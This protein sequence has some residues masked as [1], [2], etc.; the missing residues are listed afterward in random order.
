MQ[1]SSNF[2]I[3]G[4][5]HL[6]AEFQDQSMKRL[7]IALAA[8]LLGVLSIWPALAFFDSE[9][10]KDAEFTYARIRYHMTPDAIYQREVP[11]HHDYPYGDETF[12][13]FVKEVTHVHT[14]STAYQI[15]D[16]DSPDLFKYPFAYLCEPGYLELNEKDT[17][18]FR[19][20]LERGGF[21]MIDD[22]RGERHL[23]N[24]VYQLK[25]AFPD[26]NIIP[27]TLRH[28]IFDS[29]YKIDSLEMPPPYG[30]QP[31]Q[32]LGMEDDHG[33]LMLVIDYNND[34]SEIWQWLDE[35]SLPLH[36]AA[37]SLKFGT[38]YLMYAF[39]H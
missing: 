6:I 33:R 21:V 10:P 32:F 16:I 19:E 5:L 23:S 20:Y 3:S 11:W 17:K 30:S 7:L 15:V 26:K 28:S 9:P 12:P 34:L 25:K 18:N 2:K 4:K 38:N 22:F 37:E 27:L 13:A 36:D 35:G 8:I 29:F 1:D 31:V 14:A 24:L 39:T